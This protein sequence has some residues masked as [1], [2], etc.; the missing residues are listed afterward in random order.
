MSETITL[1]EVSE[2]E[3]FLRSKVVLAQERGAE[4]SRA[5]LNPKLFEHQKD[6]ALWAIRGGNRAIFAAFGL[7]KTLIQVQILKSILGR[8]DGCGLIV[9]P[10]GVKAEFVR[11][12]KKFFRLK[13]QYVPTNE[14]FEAA[15]A[16]D[17]QRF[18]ITNYER[19]RDGAIDPNLFQVVSL[20]ES[21]VLR[22]FGSKT[23]QSF[24]TLFA[25]VPFKFVCTATPS[26]NRFKELIHYAGFLGV[27][28]TGQALTRFFKRDST[29]AGN[30][31]IHPHKEKEFWLWVSSWATFLTKP[32]D[33][34]YSDKGYDLP[35]LSIWRHRLPVDHTTA[36][37]DSWGQGKLLRDAAISLREAA[38]EKRDSLKARIACAQEI[39]R[40]AGPETHWLI[41]HD[42]EDERREIEQAF[43]RAVTVYGSQEIEDR[44]RII[45]DFSDGKIPILATKPIIAGSGCNFQRHC[46]S[47][48]Y[49]GIGWKFNDFIQ[50]VHRIQRF[51]QA[52][53]VNIH[54]IYTESEDSVHDVLMKKWDRHKQL[55]ENMTRIIRENGLNNAKAGAEM[56]RSIGVRRQELK[57]ERFTCV[58]NDNVLELERIPENSVHLIVTSVPFGNQYEYCESYND[59]GHNLSDV[60]FF[61]QS[62]F[63]TPQL[64][65]A[66]A[67]GRM[68]CIHAKDRLLYGS[69]TGL[70]MYSV[71][72]F[73]DKCVTHM[74]KHGFV[75]CGRI[76]I[77]TDVVRENNQTYRLGWTEKCKDGTKMGVGSPEYILLFRKLPSDQTRSYADLP[78]V[79]SKENYTRSRWQFDASPF[80]RSRGDRFLRPEE[81]RELPQDQLRKLWHEWNAIHVYSFQE[82]VEIAE[83]LERQ[84]LLPASFMLLDPKSHSPWVW[85][86]VVRMRTL[87]ADQARGRLE[88]HV[89]PLQFDIV[90]RLLETYSAPGELVLDPFAGLMTVPYLAVQMGRKGY[91]IE[92]NSAYWADGVGYCRLAE[93]KAASPTLFDLLE[94]VSA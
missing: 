12:A 7:G 92:L 91:G 4:I 8:G 86:D 57:G 31:T 55:V 42:L 2:Y 67:P 15:R 58:N 5:S 61:R 38:R 24:L 44:E 32:S 52:H 70:G 60:E 84:G 85:D 28:D 25:R 93:Q 47:A 82:H 76:T 72:P 46:H 90:E 23:Y 88:M 48:I 40:Q 41:W 37:S 49:L 66:L 16:I 34:G 89:C 39:V 33:L 54:L 50:S 1:P 43:P 83:H 51:L 45:A 59:Y 21:S 36:G 87:N 13:L 81:I 26:P 30:L 11:D 69:V 27:M 79:K 74:Q 35:V 77:V 78:V 71:N 18:F 64:L 62:D 56:Q 94:E 10:L 75:Y 17:S 73:S 53:P 19:V 68:C 65:R 80:W 63:L 29:Q 14:D 20:D 6:I 3:T 9:C 22:S